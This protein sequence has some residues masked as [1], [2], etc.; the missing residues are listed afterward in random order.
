MRNAVAVLYQQTLTQLILLPEIKTQY[1]NG[2]ICGNREQ[3]I[4][5]KE[6]LS[7]HGCDVIQFITK[8]HALIKCML[9]ITGKFPA[10]SYNGWWWEGRGSI[11]LSHK[12]IHYATSSKFNIE[13]NIVTKL[14]MYFCPLFDIVNVLISSDIFNYSL[15]VPLC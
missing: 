5:N 14:Q 15:R 1:G 2:T 11:V 4:P 12:I 6:V 8:K 3:P 10:V 7:S 9:L 13:N